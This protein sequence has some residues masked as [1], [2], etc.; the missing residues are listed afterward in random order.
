MHDALDTAVAQLKPPDG[1]EEPS[2]RVLRQA[3]YLDHDRK[4]FLGNQS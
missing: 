3:I 4:G 2:E 1:V